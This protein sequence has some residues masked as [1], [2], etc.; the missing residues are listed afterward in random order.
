LRYQIIFSNKS[1]KDLKKLDKAIVKRIIDYLRKYISNSTNPR[2]YGSA[3]KST[4]SGYWRYRVGAYR[5]IVQIIDD[6]C[7][8]QTIKIGHRREI[9]SIGKQ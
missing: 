5:I 8:V 3:L 1:L 2:K 4:L 7:I 9:Y 6:T